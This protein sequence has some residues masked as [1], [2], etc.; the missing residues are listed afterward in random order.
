MP[1]RKVRRRPARPS[2]DRTPGL[3]GNIKR[4]FLSFSP[5][6]FRS[7]WLSRD[8]LFRFAKLAG[9]VVLFVFLVFLWYAKDLPSP[10]KINAQISATTT[11]FY[12]RTGTKLLYELY[13]DKN[14]SPIEFAQIPTNIKNA[15][16]SVED[17]D[18]YKHGAFSLFGIAR[19]L[20]GVVFHNANAGG[21]STITQQYVKNALL[22]NEHSYS[23]KIKE[24]ILS[25]EI[26]QF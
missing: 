9:L 16:V 25:M 5:K 10:S 26:E 24:L 23:R 11:K 20:Q 22:T 3:I 18:F 19:A 8:G 1:A 14:R 2:Q 7:Y 21:G 17:K 13:G 4:F 12:D 6:N 15:T